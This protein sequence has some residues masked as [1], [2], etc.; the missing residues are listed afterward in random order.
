MRRKSLLPAPAREIRASNGNF[1]GYLKGKI[2]FK[3]VKGSVHKYRA[4]GDS[5][6]WGMDYLALHSLP[7]GTVVRVEDEEEG[8]IYQ[9]PAHIIKSKGTIFHFKEGTKDH[10]T[11]VFLPVEMWEQ[12]RYE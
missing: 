1:I 2:L 12:I 4:V 5:G 3:R 8:V 9:C 6:A 11:Q 7:K 10:Y